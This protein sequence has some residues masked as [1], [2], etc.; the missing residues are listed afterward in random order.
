MKSGVTGPARKD[1]ILP[2]VLPSPEH[3]SRHRRWAQAA[4]PGTSA[5]RRR[6][7]GK[8]GRGKTA[9]RQHIWAKQRSTQFM[10]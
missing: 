1:G 7:P 2:C 5:L 3:H 6:S 10:N 8:R 9:G 4:A